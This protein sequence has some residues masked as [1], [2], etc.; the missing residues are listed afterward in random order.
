MAAPAEKPIPRPEYVASVLDSHEKPVDVRAKFSRNT[1][2]EKGIDAE[3]FKAKLQKLKVPLAKDFDFNNDRK[4]TQVILDLQK[5]LGFPQVD[6]PT[7]QD[8]MFGNNTFNAA[9]EAIKAEDRLA[10][11]TAERVRAAAREAAD[12]LRPLRE[13]VDRS[14]EDKINIEPNVQPGLADALDKVGGRR[15]AGKLPGNGGREVAIYI[16]KG[17]DLSKPVELIYHFHGVGSNV[18]GDNLEDPDHTSPGRNRLNQV[19][20]TAERMG[21]EGR[22]IVVVYPLSAGHRAGRGGKLPGLN[23]DADWMRKGNQSGDD[24]AKLDSEVLST[25]QSQF[26][27]SINVESRTAKGH[28]AG[29]TPLV[30]IARSGF[31]LDRIDFLDASYGGRID[32]CYPEAIKNNPDVEFNIFFIPGGGGKK[33]D[34]RAT[35]SAEGK[36]GVKLI[37][38]RGVKHGAFNENFFDYQRP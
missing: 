26:G 14:Q 1:L 4:L 35:R 7:G 30:N 3:G 6:N 37:E 20:T 8:G 19:L 15:W 33:T 25:I 23:Y 38:V 11:E 24:M 34:N 18:V 17:T 13:R 9:D 36:E 31:R 29:G 10:T 22:N 5:K 12:Q 16:P 27:Y 28:S 32:W 2:A 21:P